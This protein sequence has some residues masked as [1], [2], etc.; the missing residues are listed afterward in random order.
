ML[1]I[2]IRG[3]NKEKRKEQIRELEI[4]GTLIEEQEETSL[5]IVDRRDFD[6]DNNIEIDFK[7]MFN[8][9]NKLMMK[10]IKQ[11]AKVVRGQCLSP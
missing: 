7:I 2:K 11:L 1:L 4:E 6:K 9:K 5:L 3:Y 10:L 8:S